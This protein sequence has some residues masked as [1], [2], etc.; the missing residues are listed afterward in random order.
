MA[1][2]QTYLVLQ[3]QVADELGDRQD[4]LTPLADSSLALSPIQNAIQTAIAKWE[5][6]PFYFNEYYADAVAHPT[7]TFTTVS[8]TEFYTTSGDA[9][10]TQTGNLLANSPYLARIHVT[11]SNNRYMLTSR[12]WAYIENISTNPSTIGQPVDYAYFG[13]TLR[14][15]PIPDGAYPVSLTS[16]PRF[17]ALSADADT[18]CWTTDAYDLIRSE[19]KLIL[20][21]EVLMDNDLAARMGVAI[22]GNPANPRDRGYLYALKAESMR[23]AKSRITPSFF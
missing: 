19:A 20:A 15:Y 13:E 1:I 16:I 9:A 4:L 14:L 12:T 6:E 2:S 23:R 7:W 8:G 3:Q 22:Y 10:G 17:A 21:N 5:R 18:N 11:V